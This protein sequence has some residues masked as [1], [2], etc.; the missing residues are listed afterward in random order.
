MNAPLRPS[1]GGSGETATSCRHVHRVLT[2]DG[3]VPEGFRPAGAGIP[4]DA[5]GVRA[6]LKHEGV[7]LKARDVRSRA[8]VSSRALAARLAAPVAAEAGQRASAA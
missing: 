1:A 3:L 4:R 8:S 5:H 7:R 2:I 6:L